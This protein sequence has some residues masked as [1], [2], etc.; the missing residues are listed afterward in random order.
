VKEHSTDEVRVLVREVGGM[1]GP[2][3]GPSVARID[4]AEFV[5]VR[6]SVGD[7]K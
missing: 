1:E 6:S 5:E 4:D 7:N 3:P 2:G